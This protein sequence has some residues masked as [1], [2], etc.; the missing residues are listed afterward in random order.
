MEGQDCFNGVMRC[1]GI[2]ILRVS[3]LKIESYTE[4]SEYSA[5]AAGSMSNAIFS[6][7]ESRSPLFV[8]GHS[9]SA[10]LILRLK[11]FELG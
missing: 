2:G 11:D 10:I 5:T 6:R 8:D 1:G 4:I 3:T 7:R 9:I